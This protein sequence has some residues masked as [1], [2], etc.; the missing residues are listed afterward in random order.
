[1]SADF[2]CVSCGMPFQNPFPLDE[3]GRC[4]LCRS[5]MRGFDSAHCFG[6]YEGTLRKL[7]HVYKYGRVRT[8]VRPLGE[9][10]SRALP[11]QESFDAVIP[12]PLHWR[13]QWHRG[14]NQSE[15][16][17][18][19]I[20]RR[21]GIPVLGVL[22]RIMPTK[23][24]AGLSNTARRQNVATAF[25]CR[26]RYAQKVQGRRFLLVDDVV[27][28]GATAAACAMTLKRAGAAGVTLLT[29]ARVDRRLEGWRAESHSTV[30]GKS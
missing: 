24:Q 2:F 9:L 20:A 1:M 8:L 12:V 28:T 26:R 18:R 13:R 14:F 27:T 19:E 25:R 23:V 17:S 5:G 22:R 3:E 29:V 16:L 10:L 4:G 7:I 30:G 15:L 21:C 6:S 11:R